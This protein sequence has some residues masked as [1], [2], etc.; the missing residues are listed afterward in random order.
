MCLYPRLIVNKKYTPN[1][2]NKG[3]V[4]ELKD[5]RTLWVPVGCGNCIECRKQK[6][7]E[8]QVRLSEEI[9]NA[10]NGH[11]V[12]LTFDEPSLIKLTWEIENTQQYHKLEE[13]EVAT[14]AV[15]RFLE[16]WRKKYKKSVR[17]WL[18]TEL[19]HA[20]TERIHIHGIIWTD[21]PDEIKNIW[22]Y[23]FADTGKYV[24][25]RTINYIVKYVTKTDEKHKGYKP[26]ILTSAGIGNGYMKRT[27]KN[28]NKFKGE[29]TEEYY[30]TRAGLKT[31]LPIYYRNKLYTEEQRE[32]LWIAKLDKQERWICGEKINISQD[33]EE[34]YQTLEFYRAKNKRLGYGDYSKNWSIEMYKKQRKNLQRLKR[35]NKKQMKCAPPLPETGN[36]KQQKRLPRK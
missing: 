32:Q 8:W 34:Y 27:D 15:R 26:K 31:N 14:L 22:Q 6:A 10:K 35:G 4:P 13:N 28:N 5:I 1:V 20:N 18:I 24:N 9:R 3:I 2:K 29:K 33:E 21:T 16:R 23:G 36:T 19:G 17:H 25:E 7:R 11:F 30:K 12:T